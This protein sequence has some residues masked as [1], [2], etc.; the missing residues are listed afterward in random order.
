MGR[1]LLVIHMTLVAACF[2][3]RA[4]QA[5]EE[6]AGCPESRAFIAP[7]LNTLPEDGELYERQR[8][9][10]DMHIGEIL[11]LMGGVERAY[12]IAE[13]TRADALSKIA[14]GAEGAERRYHLDT[15]LRA[16][17]LIE[18]LDCIASGQSA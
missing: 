6:W 11:R 4:Q 7:L 8:Q 17:A 3:A 15:I 12:Q 14:V 2:P 5:P 1:A 10:I 9:A 16:D 13:A 18:I